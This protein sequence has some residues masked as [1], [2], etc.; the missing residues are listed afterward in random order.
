M[1]ETI[2]QKEAYEIYQSHNFRCSD[3]D[4]QII[5]DSGLTHEHFEILRGKLRNLQNLR[6]FCCRGN[7]LEVWED[8]E[9]HSIICYQDGCLIDGA[10]SALCDLC[11]ATK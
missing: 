11:T 4:G 9:F 2:S 3:A 7:N 8:I 6:D 5:Q 10:G 1:S